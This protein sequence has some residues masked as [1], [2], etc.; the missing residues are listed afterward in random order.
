[1][2]SQADICNIALGMLGATT[3]I[4]SINED[5]AEAIACKIHYDTALGQILRTYPWSWSKK[6]VYLALVGEEVV[7]NWAYAYAYPADCVRI[8][9]LVAGTTRNPDIAQSIPYELGNYENHKVVLTDQY[10]AEAIYS[11]RITS[12]GMFDDQ[13]VEAFANLLASKMAVSFAKPE[14]QNPLLQAYYATASEA[15]ACGMNEQNLGPEPDSF[16][17]RAR[18]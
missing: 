7:T 16:L 4:Q 3:R 14:M 1:M 11:A 2:A 6:R 5:S 13:F 18:Q 10:Q 12:T 15:F 17:L 9:S 8:W